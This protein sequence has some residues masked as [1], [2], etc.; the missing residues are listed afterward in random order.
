[1]LILSVFVC[2]LS[3]IVLANYAGYQT[4][5]FFTDIAVLVFSSSATRFGN[6]PC[7]RHHLRNAFLDSRRSN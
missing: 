3:H 4:L 2:A 6:P 7:D 1:M 5:H